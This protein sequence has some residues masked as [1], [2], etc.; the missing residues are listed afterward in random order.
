[1]LDSALFKAVG[2]L[3]SIWDHKEKNKY[4]DRYLSLKK[5]YRE[6]YNRPENERSRAELDRIKSE[7]CDL[8]DSV[9]ATAGITDS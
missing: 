1:M 4:R 6:E 8:L 3:L 9:T 7:L 5:E 2:S